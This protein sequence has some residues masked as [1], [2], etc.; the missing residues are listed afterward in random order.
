MKNIIQRNSTH[1]LESKNFNSKKTP[2]D[3]IDFSPDKNHHYILKLK[4]NNINSN[5][6]RLIFNDNQ[7]T[8]IVFRS[9]EFN[10][11]VHIRNYK[12]HDLIDNLYFDE[13]KSIDFTLPED[14]FYLIEH[15][16]IPKKNTLEVIFGKLNYN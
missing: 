2:A 16:V 14:D 10:N 9:I 7:L 3:I 5:N 8:V 4:I 15:S 12:L 1:N 6:Y 11:P 13:L